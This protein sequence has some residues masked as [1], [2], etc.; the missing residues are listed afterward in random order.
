MVRNSPDAWGSAAKSLHWTV[1]V[2]VGAQIPLGFGAVAARMSPLKLDL[3]VWHKSVG[4]LILVLTGFRLAWRLANPT[5]APPAGSARWERRAAGACHALLYASLVAMA[6]S[7]WIIN[8]SSNIPFRVFWQ[9]PLPPI[10]APDEA[11]A[12][13]ATRAHHGILAFLLAL[14]VI[15]IGAAARHH[16]VQRDEVLARMLP[17][18]RRP[19]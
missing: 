15:H 2:L 6:I 3:F 8:S 17:G 16:L 12:H 18:A 4:M 9:V 13:A 11:V 10:A 7:G 1:A 5:P 19:T 14:L